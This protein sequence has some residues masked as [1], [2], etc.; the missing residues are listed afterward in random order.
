VKSL[1]YAFSLIA[2]FAIVPFKASS[3]SA[4]TNAVKNGAISTLTLQ[5]DHVRNATGVIRFAIFANDAGWPDNK[6]KSIRYGSLPAQPGTVT[7]TLAGIPYGTYAISVFH[8]E[9]ENHKVD[10]DFFGRPKEG[11]GFGNNPKIGFT[12]PS[13]TASSI[14]ITSPATNTTIN[15]RYP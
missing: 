5:V 11:I 3:Q 10:R 8:D 7:F 15:L 1:I 2:L 9:N 14:K 12:I 4:A 13:W 6:L